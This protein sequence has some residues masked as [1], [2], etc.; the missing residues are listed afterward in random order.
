MVD[1]HPFFLL[2]F[3]KRYWMKIVK[4]LEKIPM[5][6]ASLVLAIPAVIGLLLECI[7]LAFFG[8]LLYKT[9]D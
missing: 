3:G 6:M 8:I 2:Y 4:H 9:R 7:P 1:G 5:V